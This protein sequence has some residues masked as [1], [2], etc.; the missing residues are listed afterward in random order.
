MG[1]VGLFSLKKGRKKAL[2]IAAPLRTPGGPSCCVYF[3]VPAMFCLWSGAAPVPES[4]RV[5]GLK[6]GPGGT[7]VEGKL[8]DAVLS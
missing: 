7:P 1:T 3:K 6:P 5:Q 2:C 8:E 4:P